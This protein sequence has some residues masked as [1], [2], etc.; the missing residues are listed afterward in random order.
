MG[1]AQPNSQEKKAQAA[2][3]IMKLEVAG[4]L[5]L[6]EKIEQLGW[7]SLSAV[8]AGRIGGIVAARLKK[9][10]HNQ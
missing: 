2:R 8:E 1:T 4:E 10:G 7:G 9:G 6:L 3:E 5:G